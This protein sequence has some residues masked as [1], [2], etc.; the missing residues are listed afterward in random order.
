[1]K[2]AGR[3]VDEIDSSIHNLAANYRLSVDVNLE[4]SATVSKRGA[5]EIR[6]QTEWEGGSQG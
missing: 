4:T 5:S 3:R 2:L 6:T 1:M